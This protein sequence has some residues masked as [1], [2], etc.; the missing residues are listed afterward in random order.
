MCS[1]LTT[2]IDGIQTILSHVVSNTTL[3][4][5]TRRYDLMPKLRVATAQRM[6]IIS[7]EKPQANLF[8][9]YIAAVFES[10]INPDPL[11]GHSNGIDPTA[12]PIQATNGHSETGSTTVVRD[13][14]PDFTLPTAMT[15]PTAKTE[16]EAY[17]ELSEW[18]V[19]LLTPIAFYIRD[20]L[21][22]ERHRITQQG[23]GIPGS[24][25]SHLTQAKVSGSMMFLHQHLQ[26]LGLA[27]PD[28]QS[29][30]T[31]GKLWR[32]ICTVNL[33]DGERV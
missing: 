27:M 10:A 20:Y 15:V 14:S 18:L 12:S 7:S 2:D 11:P 22:A 1:I 23:N 25:D 28:Y 5:L 26:Q 13:E 17:D 6:T 32:T 21:Q 3:A 4:Y 33:A 8:E 19:P 16:G 31:E 29:S 9:A 30:E 24:D